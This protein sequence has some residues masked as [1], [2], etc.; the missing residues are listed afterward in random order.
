[1]REILFR[2]KRIDTGGWIN[3]FYAELTD[4]TGQGVEHWIF[5]GEGGYGIPTDILFYRQYLIN[6]E[7]V[8][9]YTGFKDLNESRIFEGDIIEDE[10]RMAALVVFEEGSFFADYDGYEPQYLGD[11]GEIIGNVFDNPELLEA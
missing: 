2:G 10:S 4:G 3:G 8:G 1:M 5:T 11:W 6:P 9:Q 7:T